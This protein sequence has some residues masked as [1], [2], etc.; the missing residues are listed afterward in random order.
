M[1]NFAMSSTNTETMSDSYIRRMNTLLP[2]LALSVFR[3]LIA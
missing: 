2:L 1:T 3:E